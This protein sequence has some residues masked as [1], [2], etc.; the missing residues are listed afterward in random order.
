MSKYITLEEAK[1]HL[2]VDFYDD[3]DYIQALCDMTEMAVE[4]EIGAPLTGLTPTT[5]F[6]SY[7][8]TIPLRLKQGMLLM[9]GHFYSNRESLIIGVNAM[10][11]P[12][13]FDWL[14]SPYKVWTVK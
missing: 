7:G 6:T 2:R 10:K 13:G 9:I 12:M 11:I 4:E 8:T 1:T 14:I 3:D 5:G